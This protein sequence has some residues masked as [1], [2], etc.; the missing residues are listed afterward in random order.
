MRGH[1]VLVM[2]GLMGATMARAEVMPVGWRAATPADVDGVAARLHLAAADRFPGQ[3]LSA[4]G[5]FDGDG[6]ADRAAVL[7]DGT[8]VRLGVFVFR[9]A[10]GAAQKIEDEPIDGLVNIGLDLQAAGTFPTACGKGAG[11][12][13]APCRPAITTKQASIAIT[14]FEASQELV[15]WT[16]KRFE[17]AFLSD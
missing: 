11:A 2:A 8:G 16:G 6:R 10:G 7:V 4:I 15:F 13:G 1:V 14:H 17:R 12:K 5:D 3:Q 9:G